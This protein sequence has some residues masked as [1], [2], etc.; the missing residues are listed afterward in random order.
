MD[1]VP[2]GS[3]L[4]LCRRAIGAVALAMALAMSR[5]PAEALTSIMENDV[6]AFSRRADQWT[7]ARVAHREAAHELALRLADDARQAEAERIAALDVARAAEIA[8]QEAA[9]TSTTTAPPTTAAT[10]TAAPSTAPSTTAA[11]STAPSTATTEPPT[12][13]QWEVLRQCESTGNYTVKGRYRGVYQFSQATWDWVASLDHPSLVGVDPAL[14]APA[15][16][17]AMALA[18]WLRQGWNP[19]PV[20][21]AAAAA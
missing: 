13:A 2:D 8:R 12:A 4:P 18:L 16:Q 5:Q 20:C 6:A 9:R 3:R 15:V 14:A 21:G 10:T 11:P 19:W 17:D 7:A 1:G